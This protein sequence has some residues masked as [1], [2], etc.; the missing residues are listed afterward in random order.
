MGVSGCSCVGVSQV[1][2]VGEELGTPI[3]DHLLQSI[4]TGFEPWRGFDGLFR[5]IPAL[6]SS[7]F[8]RGGRVW[9]RGSKPAGSG[10]NQQP[11]VC[12]AEFS[13]YRFPFFRRPLVS[14]RILFGR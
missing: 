2:P 7:E 9:G 1:Q 11:N 3:A 4:R 12:R 5:E 6:G 8:R 14:K 13:P 10:L